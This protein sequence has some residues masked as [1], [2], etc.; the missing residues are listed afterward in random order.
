MFHLQYFRLAGALSVLHDVED[1]FA[2][3]ASDLDEISTFVPLH[4]SA[5]DTRFRHAQHKLH[6]CVAQRSSG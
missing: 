6:Y 5:A 1:S 2:R 3:A 4:T